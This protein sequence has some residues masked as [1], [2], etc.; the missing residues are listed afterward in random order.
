MIVKFSAHVCKC[1]YA[2]LSE[3]ILPGIYIYTLL[4]G[5][6]KIQVQ[7]FHRREY[8]ITAYLLI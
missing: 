5:L 7:I 4:S 2:N 1:T 6:H 8:Q 3:F